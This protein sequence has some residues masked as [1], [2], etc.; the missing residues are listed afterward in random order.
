MNE[1]SVEV[2]E[3]GQRVLDISLAN[4]IPHTH[5]CGGN[6]R[7]S[8]CRIIVL[9]GGQN[10]TPP[11]Q[12]ELTLAARKGF[13]PDIRLAC[14]AEVQGD[15]TIRRLVFDQDDIQEII[16]TS[17]RTT[18]RELNAAVLFSDIR[19]FTTFSERHLPYD[20]V[21][22]LNRYF[23]EMG[24]A[25]IRH[26][27]HIDKYMG[28]G[29]MALFGL[30]GEDGRLACLAAVRAAVSMLSA[31]EN[32]NAY[33]RRTYQEEFKIGIGI[34]FG[35]VI[36]GEMG[37]PKKIQFTALGDTVNTASRIETATKKAGASI[38][39]SDAAYHQIAGEVKRGRVFSAPLKGKTGRFKLYEILGVSPSSDSAQELFQLPV[40]HKTS[41]AAET[42]ALHLDTS[43][44]D[45]PFK[46]GQFIEVTLPA[47]ESMPG[48]ASRIFSIASSPHRSDS[49][50][51]ATR[52]RR[53][54]FKKTLAALEEGAPLWVSEPAGHLTP[55][56]PGPRP[57]AFI[58]GGMGVTV[59]RSLI[60]HLLHEEPERPLYL[61]LSN[62][63]LASAAFL[64]EMESWAMESSNFHVTATL[65]EEVPPGWKFE[66]GRL[67]KLMLQKHLPLT[68]NPIFYVAGPP[69]MVASVH[70]L[71]LS[72][73]MPDKDIQVEEFHG[74]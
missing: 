18:G 45:F 32:V 13:P 73:S 72:L 50:M 41:V 30:N 69:R 2:S 14:R 66:R 46:P 28:D 10:L 4:G 31:L 8:T 11:A 38:L 70:E 59:C 43:L 64:D 44:N 60:E 57:V 25:V 15:V 55:P 29:L 67:D 61:I 3:K 19:G 21:H 58:A 52:I 36:A 68:A 71:L 37:H 7:C 33:M 74:Y 22:L 48:Q 26:G 9:E 34:H 39:I 40:L 20:V 27:G 56:P 6:A 23:R 24:D 12:E 47:L 53:S 5:V 17:I 42:I 49:I 16:A 65:T 1:K 54:L 35:E 62:R 51:I 63:T